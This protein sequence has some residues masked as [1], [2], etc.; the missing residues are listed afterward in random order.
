MLSLSLTAK[1][2]ASQGQQRSTVL[3]LKVA[4]MKVFETELGEKPI[5]VLDDVFSELD[6]TRQKKMYEML[7]GTQVMMTGTAFRF[8]PNES[9]MQFDVKDANIK[10]KF[11]EK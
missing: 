5:F 6:S 11:N 7:S 2:F 1:I 3:A 4:E 8:K 10:V 9:Y